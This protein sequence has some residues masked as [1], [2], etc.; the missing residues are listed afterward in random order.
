MERLSRKQYDSTTIFLDR[1]DEIGKMS[2]ALDEFRIDLMATEELK[3]EQDHLRTKLESDRAETISRVA[4]HLER[5]VGSTVTVIETA[6]DQLSHSAES[7]L[8]AAND[9]NRQVSFVV[10]HTTQTQSSIETLVTASSELSASIREIGRLV[11]FS[12]QIVG[13]ALGDVEKSNQI[14]TELAAGAVQVG[15]V[16]DLIESIAGQ[17][18]LLALNATIEAARAGE[19]GRGFAVVASEV[20][21]LANQT[22]RATQGYCSANR[23]NAKHYPRRSYYDPVDQP[24]RR[25]DGNHC[26][27][28]LAGRPSSRISLPTK[29]Q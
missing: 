8:E 22:A 25:T 20:K 23:R 9:T 12:S 11:E 6:V 28:H 16:V 18:N 5:Q 7:M 4:Q 14:V 15:K 2:K 13:N 10:G 19:A 1:K 26:Q 17:T 29:F 27:H 3:R 24:R 21:A